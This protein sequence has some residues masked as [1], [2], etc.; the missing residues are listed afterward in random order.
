[1]NR[2]VQSERWPISQMTVHMVWN[3]QCWPPAV[4]KCPLASQ[5]ERPPTTLLWGD[6]NHLPLMVIAF[7]GSS[8][9]TPNVLHLLQ[10]SLKINLVARTSLWN[11]SKVNC[12]T[13]VN[14]IVRSR[15]SLK[16]LLSNFPGLFSFREIYFYFAFQFHVRNFEVG[17]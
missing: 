3:G 4:V 5:T 16:K 2:L 1:M 11:I 12:F 9:V 8:T 13:L 17:T 6:F 15:L 10:P 7:N 14:L